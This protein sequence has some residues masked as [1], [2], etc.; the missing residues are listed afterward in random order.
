MVVVINSQA[1]F[2][3]MMHSVN[4]GHS[5]WENAIFQMYIH[6]Q[7]LFFLGVSDVIAITF[8]RIVREIKQNSVFTGGTNKQNN[9]F[10]GGTSIL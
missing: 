3:A 7:T 1:Y 5:I 4:E 2:F 10:T 6:I 8:E 9:V